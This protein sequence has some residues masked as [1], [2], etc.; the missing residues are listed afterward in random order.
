MTHFYFLAL[1][2]IHPILSQQYNNEYDY[3]YGYN[4][5]MI[6]ANKSI[7]DNIDY[8]LRQISNNKDENL[9]LVIPSFYHSKIKNEDDIRLNIINNILSKN[10][11]NQKYVVEYLLKLGE[12]LESKTFDFHD[13]IM[14]YEFLKF[15]LN[16][17]KES[18]NLPRASTKSVDDITTS[19]TK[20]IT[21]ISH[22]TTTLSMN[23]SNED[24][25]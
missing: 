22:S 10:N 14:F 4:R 5:N 19:S 24:D 17:S 3:D 23:K 13:K 21:L 7:L 20:L 8:V 6:D 9:L 18:G 1:L 15:L 11:L 2:L 12:T 25:I 16:K